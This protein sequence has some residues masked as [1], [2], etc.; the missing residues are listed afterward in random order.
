MMGSRGPTEPFLPAFL[1]HALLLQGTQPPAEMS[2]A[3]LLPLKKSQL[4][5][6]AI[7]ND[8]TITLSFTLFF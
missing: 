4:G 5:K 7:Q 3:W 6:E 1:P 2:Q 8:I